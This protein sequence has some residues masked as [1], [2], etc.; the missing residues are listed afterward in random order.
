MF[1]PL[2]DGKLSSHIKGRAAIPGALGSG[3]KGKVQ[4][5]SGKAVAD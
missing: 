2:M 5:Y 4:A 1:F 3:D